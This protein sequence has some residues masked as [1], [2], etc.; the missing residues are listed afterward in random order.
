MTLNCLCRH[1]TSA[2]SAAFPHSSSSVVCWQVTSSDG[3]GQCFISH[4]GPFFISGVIRVS[5]QFV[6][7]SASWF[8]PIFILGHLVISG[9]AWLIIMPKL[10]PAHYLV[11]SLTAATH[12]SLWFPKPTL[13]SCNGFTVTHI[14]T[15]VN[16]NSC[17]GYQCSPTLITEF[18]LSPSGHQVILI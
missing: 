10:S 13:T 6:Q 15:G 14:I 5:T 8:I 3:N 2:F 11:H 4:F 7:K 16:F 9:S 12:C 1:E 18:P 17:T